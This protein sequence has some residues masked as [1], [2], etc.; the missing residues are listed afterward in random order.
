MS[1]IVF[2]RAVMVTASADV[3]RI[4]Y[5]QACRIDAD[6]TGLTKS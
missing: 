2:M 4:Q 3:N 1:I 6:A 5:S